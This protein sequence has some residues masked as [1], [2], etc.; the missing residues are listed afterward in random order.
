[1][2]VQRRLR[3]AKRRLAWLSG[4]QQGTFTEISTSGMHSY[5]E[6][7]A[8][9]SNGPPEP[10][11]QARIVRRIDGRYAI[12]Y[13]QGSNVSRLVYVAREE[14]DALDR[15]FALC[16]EHLDAL[17]HAERYVRVSLSRRLRQHGRRAF[18]DIVH[19]L[20]YFLLKRHAGA[21]GTRAPLL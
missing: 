12:E 5:Q 16:Q 19:Q 17:G 13:P 18:D 20:G 7:V 9:E 15:S 8:G 4:A 1:V 11:T 3:R 21:I 14:L 2:S 6:F 10:A